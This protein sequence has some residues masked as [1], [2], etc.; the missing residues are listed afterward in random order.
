MK[1]II[2]YIIILIA[3]IFFI[4]SSHAYDE[5]IKL[6]RTN[7]TEYS[8]EENIKVTLNGMQDFKNIKKANE[9]H[10][11]V[12]KYVKVTSQKF[13]KKGKRSKYRGSAVN[14]YS[15]NADSVVYIGNKRFQ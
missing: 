14:I 3:S 2:K 11:A 13:K 15:K 4:S 12:E 9:K 6:N 7:V 8:G 1:I 10:S 5:S